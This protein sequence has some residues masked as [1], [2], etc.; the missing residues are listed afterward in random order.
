MDIGSGT[1]S[2]LSDVRPAAEG[3]APRWARR[4]G[5]VLLLVV[6]V[7]GALGVFGVHS[8][9]VR[10]ASAGYTMTVT[11][12]E[13]AR[14]GLDVPF[15]IEVHHDGGFT[16][17]LT[18][19]VTMDYF[20]M[21]ETQNFFPSADRETNSGKYMYFS[22]DKPRG[23]NFDLEYDAYIQPSSQIGKGAHIELIVA[24]QI[25]ARTSVRTWLMP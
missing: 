9:T 5:V 24:G 7:A 18:L 6:V 3:P 4:T 13:T 17:G 12:A 1:G 25:V 11:Y 15:R 21:F 19:A 16:T 2:T 10:T 14:A 20:R 23:S 22:F 8:R